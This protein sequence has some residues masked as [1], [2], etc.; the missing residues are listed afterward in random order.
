MLS[1]IIP[2]RK[3]KYLNNTI[4]DILKKAVGEIEIVVVLDGYWEIPIDDKR[5]KY[6]HNGEAM[7]MR[8]SI[9]RGIAIAKYEFILK[10]DA[11]CM[12]DKGF[13]K[14][15]LE[16][17]QDKQVQVPTRKRL[18]AKEWKIK[19][20]GRSDINY[21]ILDENYRGVLSHRVNKSDK[22]KKKMVDEIEAFQGSCWFMGRN[23]YNNCKFLDVE[24]FG[25]MGHEAQEIYFK[26]KNVGGKVIRNKYTW[27]AHY[28]KEIATTT[29]NRSKSRDYI[30]KYV[31]KM[32]KKKKFKR[33]DLAKMF[34]GKGAEVGVRT[35]K[36]SE[37][38][39]QVGKDIELLSVDPYDLPYREKRS[40][41][42]GIEKQLLYYKEATD[43]L[44][45]YNCKLIKKESLDAVRD[46]PYES[47]DFVYIDGSHQ[48]DYVM[49]DIIEWAKRVKVGGI[50]SGHDYYE[51]KYAGVVEAVDIYCKIHNLKFN[52]TN[53]RTPSWWFI[54]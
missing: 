7:G 54:K 31:K 23:F 13:D 36:Y 51:F 45:S 6:I 12:F 35:G 17:H 39:C 37:I 42:M 5:V 11:H 53:D 43:R 49:C 26:V 2:S 14:K 8:T 50:I 1:V 25:E 40:E 16:Q 27:Y 44:K 32:N 3:E 29:S 52:L 9:N 30:I 41:I 21:L 48:F 33:R 34:K 24:N 4:K 19:E 20:D 47:L 38:I 18:N 15:L 46:I 28:H 10:C 22:L